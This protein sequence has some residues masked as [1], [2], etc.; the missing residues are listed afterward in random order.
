MNAVWHGKDVK[1]VCWRAVACTLIRAGVPVRRIAEP[2]NDAEAKRLTIEVGYS[3]EA[4]DAPPIS[5]SQL[6]SMR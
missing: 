1:P 6:W 3:G 4:R 5:V 2:V